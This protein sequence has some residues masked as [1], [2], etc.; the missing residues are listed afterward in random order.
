[1]ADFTWGSGRTQSAL[2]FVATLQGIGAALSSTIG[3]LLAARIGWASAFLGLSVPAIFAFGL[4]VRLLGQGPGSRW[5]GRRE[6][7]V[8]GQ[9]IDLA[10]F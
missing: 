3:G 4:A 5:L 6:A 1:V 10:A 8:L 7:V 2:G 9:G